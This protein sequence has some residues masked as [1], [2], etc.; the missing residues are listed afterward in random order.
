[1][2]HVKNATSSHK[3]KKKKNKLYHFRL[4]PLVIF[5]CVLML[6]VHVGVLW[7][8]M[9]MLHDSEM[10]SVVAVTHAQ[11]DSLASRLTN[12][13]RDPDPLKDEEVFQDQNI[14]E[15]SFSQSELEILKKLAQRREELD[16]RERQINQKA[17]ILKAAEEQIDVKIA[18]LK[19]LESSIKDLIGVYDE[20][21]RN[22][23]D[24]LVKI[25]SA[26]KPKEAARLFD[27]MELSLL[28]RVFERMKEAKAAPILAMMDPEKANTLTAQ[29]A[30][31]K[32]LPEYDGSEEIDHAKDQKK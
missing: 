5:A 2:K 15:K 6:T 14:A 9:I 28:V 20:K 7:R 16:V 30:S 17:G 3:E 25:Y 13:V 26:M 11:A 27:N 32:S 12:A 21:E 18:K 31:K 4:L 29:L 1:M 19:E 23:L 10:S 24:T 22:R 8:K